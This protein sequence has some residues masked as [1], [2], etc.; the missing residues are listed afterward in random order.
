VFNSKDIVDIKD[1]D[2]V[3]FKTSKNKFGFVKSK[4]S[5]IQKYV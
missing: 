2:F 5:N 1:G 4:D 3:V